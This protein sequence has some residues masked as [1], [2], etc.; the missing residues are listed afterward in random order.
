MPAWK[1][2]PRQPDDGP[3]RVARIRELPGYLEF[4]HQAGNLILSDY[5]AARLFGM[6]AMF[7]EIKLPPKLAKAIVLTDPGVKMDMTLDFPEPKTLGE[8]LAQALLPDTIG[9]FEKV[10]Q[11]ESGGAES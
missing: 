1:M 3:L 7:L 6:L 5:N 2:P 4:N 10:A 8:A 11:P 9:D